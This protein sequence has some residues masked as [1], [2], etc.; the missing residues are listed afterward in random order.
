M[1]ITGRCYC[2]SIRYEALGP[3]LY[4]ANCHCEN[5]RRAIGA[6]AVAWITV[7]LDTFK[8]VGDPTRHHTDTE[9]TR[10]FCPDCGSS[11]TY[12]HPSRETEIDIVTAS[13]D[14]PEKFAP[15]LSVY[16]DEKLSWVKCDASN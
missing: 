13:L 12:Q 3:T 9:A 5:C 7:K 6:Q 10:T 1:K 2:G 16:A 4:Q 8:F 11:L 15:N 14:K